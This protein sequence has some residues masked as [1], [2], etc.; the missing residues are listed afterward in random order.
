MEISFWIEQTKSVENHGEKLTISDGFQF[1]FSTSRRA[2][3]KSD[4]II[5]TLLCLRHSSNMTLKTYSIK[6]D[7]IL[8]SL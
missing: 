1:Q 8:K 3:L 5:N 4:N 6:F 2:R 7:G